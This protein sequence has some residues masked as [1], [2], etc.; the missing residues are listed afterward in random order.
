MFAISDPVPGS[1]SVFTGRN[2]GGMADQGDQFSLTLHLQAEHTKAIL[3]VVEGD[4]FNET[5]EA[6][7]VS[8][9]RVSHESEPEAGPVCRTERLPRKPVQVIAIGHGVRHQWLQVVDID[10]VIP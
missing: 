5:G 10:P 3:F 6:V 7:K 8:G 2:D 1:R 4:T 9:A